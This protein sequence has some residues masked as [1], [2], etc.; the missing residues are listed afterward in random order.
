MFIRV[1]SKLIRGDAMV[2]LAENEAYCTKCRKGQVFRDEEIV[3]Y[4]TKKGRKKAKKGLCTVCGNKT[5][6]FV[7]M[8]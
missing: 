5:V 3:Y 1:H 8:D 4:D 2:I 6:K 7:K